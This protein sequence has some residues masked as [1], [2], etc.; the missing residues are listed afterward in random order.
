MVFNVISV[1]AGRRFPYRVLDV[2]VVPQVNPCVYRVLAGLDQ[3]QLF[4]FCNRC[5]QFFRHLGLRL[6]QHIFADRLAGQWIVAYRVAAFPS[7]V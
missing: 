5:L 2:G 6:C 3:V 1:I 7:T 4:R